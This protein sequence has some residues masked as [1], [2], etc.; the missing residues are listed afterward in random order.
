MDCNPQVSS[1]HWIPQA[2]ILEWVTISI[3]RGSSQPR[4]RAHVSYI[5]KQILYHW[6]TREAHLS[7]DKWMQNCG[8]YHGKLFTLKGEGNSDT[9]YNTDESWRHY[10]SGN[11]SLTKEQMLCVCA[12]V[13]VCVCVRAHT[14][15]QSTV[16]LFE[17]P[18]SSS[19]LGSSVHGIFQARILDWVVISF[20]RASSWSR[21]GTCVSCTSRW[22][23]YY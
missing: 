12:C 13:C 1:V 6:D 23:L 16:R 3:S 10:A 18:W 2:R 22:I 4:D 20:S 7:T 14:P 19:P 9:G 5:G 17:T 21:H 11:N 15:A 8:P